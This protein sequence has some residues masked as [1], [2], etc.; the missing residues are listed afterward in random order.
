MFNYSNIVENRVFEMMSKSND[1]FIPVIIT[2]NDCEYSSLEGCIKDLGGIVKHRLH[3][4]NAVAVHLPSNNIRSLSQR[5]QIS[6]VHLDDIVMK[7]MDKA[8]TTVAS[9]YA[10]SHGLTG[11]DI[12]VAVIDTGV[13][14]HAD[15]TSPKNRIVKFLDLVNKKS[16]PYDDDGHGTH[17]A[18][19]IAGNGFS[20]RGKYTG[21]A[22]DAKIIAIKSLDE[23][24]GGN[25][26]DVIAGIQWAIENKD[27]YNIKVITLSLGI[28][29]K[30]SYRDDPLCQA[31]TQ[32]KNK[33]ITVV[34]AA[35]NS[36]PNPSTISSPAISPHAI[37]VGACDD[38]KASNPQDCSIANF[39]SRGPTVDKISKPDVLAPGV[40]IQSLSN[41]DGYTSLTGTSMAAPIVAGCIALLYEENPNLTYQEIQRK[42]SQGSIDLGEEANSQGAGLLDFK[43]IFDIP[44]PSQ[45]DHDD[46]KQDGKGLSPS[47]G[48]WLIVIIILLLILLI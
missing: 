21:I 9:H 47:Q 28:K 31:V 11:K 30:A 6:R 39:S 44:P 16:S 24:G 19:I 48:N 29:T 12:G 25:V 27:P 46:K 2:G 26:S 38:R 15:L 45:K 14:P 23:N 37:S 5:E 18:G 20:S 43:K 13:H 3:I 7:M 36:G 41:E 4:I 34:V 33:N 17:V 35:G 22:P 32:A 8:S 40:G 1:E 42:I 10:N